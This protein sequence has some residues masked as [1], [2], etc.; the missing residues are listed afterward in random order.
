[1]SSCKDTCLQLFTLILLFLTLI[2]IIGVRMA[3]SGCILEQLKQFG[4]S[5]EEI[6]FAI[7]KAKNPKDINEYMD[8]IIRRKQDEPVQPGLCNSVSAHNNIRKQ[9]A[10][11]QKVE[12]KDGVN[13]PQRMAKCITSTTTRNRRIG[14][15]L[16]KHIGQ[17]VLAKMERFT[18]RTIKTKKRI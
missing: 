2:C 9:T 18:I 14:E 11:E 10:Q 16:K 3:Q 1:M 12:Q 17:K 7:R 6:M 15:F 8:I 13:A 4:Y 5:D